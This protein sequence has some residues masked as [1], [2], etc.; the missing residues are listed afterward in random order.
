LKS[1][2]PMADALT[3]AGNLNCAALLVDSSVDASAENA[4]RALASAMG[5][6]LI[7]LEDLNREVLVNVARN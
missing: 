4:T 3:A 7:R 6:K 1:A 2:D 5:A